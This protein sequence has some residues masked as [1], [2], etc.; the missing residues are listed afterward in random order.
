VEEALE[1]EGLYSVVVVFDGEVAD[2]SA[3]VEDGAAAVSDGVGG[4]G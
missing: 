1:A 3:L 2:G 4:V